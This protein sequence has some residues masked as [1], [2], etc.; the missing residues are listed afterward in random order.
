MHA[1]AVHAQR[2]HAVKACS[3]PSHECVCMSVHNQVDFS[4]DANDIT[5]ARH[6]CIMGGCNGAGGSNGVHDKVGT[7]TVKERPPLAEDMTDHQLVVILDDLNPDWTGKSPANI[8]SLLALHYNISQCTAIN[9][10]RLKALKATV[11]NARKGKILGEIKKWNDERCDGYVLPQGGKEEHYID[12]TDLRTAGL[13]LV[14][15]QKILYRLGKKG[16]RS[17]AIDATNTDGSALHDG[18]TTAC[19]KK[20]S[21]TVNNIHKVHIFHDAENCW[22]GNGAIEAS[23]LVQDVLTEICT[24]TGC[25]QVAT[26]PF[27]AVL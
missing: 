16:G 9:E 17:C 2:T 11:V 22:L 20:T 10:K 25:V 15:G 18:N 19:Q 27:D 23:K 3:Q 4:I 7:S 8:R 13:Q 24:V 14:L 26:G 12:L 21:P 5:L 1:Q 6:V